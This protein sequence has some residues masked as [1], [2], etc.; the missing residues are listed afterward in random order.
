MLSAFGMRILPIQLGHKSRD[1]SPACWV[2]LILNR[3]ERIYFTLNEEKPL[4]NRGVI[5]K[6]W[7]RRELHLD[8]KL[9]I[10][11][12]LM[13]FKIRF[14]YILCYINLTVLSQSPKIS[15]FTK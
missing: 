9:L 11:I 5:L 14:C 4:K 3:L 12:G 2:D 8:Y 15:F 1:N 10:N 6:W 13:S 7:R